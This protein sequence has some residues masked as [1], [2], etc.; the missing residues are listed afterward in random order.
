[1]W[2]LWFFDS[3]VENEVFEGEGAEEAAQARFEACKQNWSCVLLQ[4]IDRG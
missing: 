4:E 1:M 2:L 3:S